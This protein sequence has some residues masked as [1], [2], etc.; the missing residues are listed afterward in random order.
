[1]KIAVC[2]KRVPDT[3]TRIKIGADGRSI[4]EEGVKFVLNPYDEYAVEQALQLK[5]SAGT[6]EVTAISLGSSASQE[7]IR[8]ALAMGVDR[9]ILLETDTIPLDPVPVGKALAAELGVAHRRPAVCERAVPD[10]YITALDGELL[11]G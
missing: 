2:L 10:Q 3:E 6:G 8:T 4:D 11:E 9:G 7:T 1:M 5:E